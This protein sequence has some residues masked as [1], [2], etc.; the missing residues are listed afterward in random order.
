MAKLIKNK[1]YKKT[2]EVGIC[3]YLVSIPKLVVSK[4]GFTDDTQ[5]KV[6]A[7]NGKIIIENV[8][9]RKEKE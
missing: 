8:S 5:V 4:A 6:Y 2:G 3:S 7:E 9:K 1:Y